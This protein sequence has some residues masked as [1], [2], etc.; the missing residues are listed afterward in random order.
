[1]KLQDAVKKETTFMAIGCAVCCVVTVLVF[2]LLHV[3]FP[4]TVPFDYKVIL[5]T[6]LGS[7]VAT[8]NFFW[9]AVTVQKVS[10]CEDDDKAKSIMRTSFRYRT[11]AQ[12]V[13]GVAAI[14]VPFINT[15]AGIVPL[16]FPGIVIK[17]RG[18]VSA[19]R[20]E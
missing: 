6:V 11:L 17:V 3:F 19:R 8:G 5:G 18:I 15:V 1:M 20:G 12:L 2:A 4:E 14:F 16:F 10:A 7:A 13:W 9:M